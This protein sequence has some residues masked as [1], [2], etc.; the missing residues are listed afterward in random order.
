MATF[1][2]S[3]MIV[4]MVEYRPARARHDSKCDANMFENEIGSFFESGDTLTVTPSNVKPN[5]YRTFAFQSLI[6]CNWKTFVTALITR[7]GRKESG[8]AKPVG[9]RRR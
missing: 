9:T 3:M 2:F 4:R 6:E 7:N 1:C 5:E 8:R